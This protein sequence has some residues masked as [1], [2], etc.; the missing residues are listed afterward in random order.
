MIV[1]C[2]NRDSWGASVGTSIPPLELTLLIHTN[3]KKKCFDR[4]FFWQKTNK[5]RYK[6]QT[7]ATSTEI[8][9][10]CSSLQ[11]IFI[12]SSYEHAVPSLTFWMR[13]LHSMSTYFCPHSTKGTFKSQLLTFRRWELELLTFFVAFH[14]FLTRWR[15]CM[16]L[17]F[18]SLDAKHSANG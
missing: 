12:R 9:L 1:F 13:P 16:D 17:W 14:W 4:S 15:V 10:S 2:F 11:S 18:T 8:K 3:C 7:S 6:K 5:I